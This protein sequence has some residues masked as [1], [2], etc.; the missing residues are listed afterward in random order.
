MKDYTERT[1]WI[2]ITARELLEKLGYAVRDPGG[3]HFVTIQKVD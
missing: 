1:T 2:T 3:K